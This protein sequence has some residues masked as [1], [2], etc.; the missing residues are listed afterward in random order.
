MIEINVISP[1]LS[2]PMQV[3]IHILGALH[4]PSAMMAV[5]AMTKGSS[6]NT[7]RELTG[8]NVNTLEPAKQQIVFCYDCLTRS[9]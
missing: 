1:T 6:A 7:G 9:R 4:G 3:H 5:G 2:Y 8:G